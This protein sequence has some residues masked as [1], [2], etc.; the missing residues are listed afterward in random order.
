MAFKNGYLVNLII[1]NKLNNIEQ[2]NFFE[3]KIEN[4]KKYIIKLT[5]L[6]DKIVDAYL[7]I[8]GRKMGAYRIIPNETIDIVRPFRRTKDL[9]FLHKKKEYSDANLFKTN[10]KK[11]GEIEVEFCSG[12]PYP[13]EE[14]IEEYQYIRNKVVYRLSDYEYNPKYMNIYKRQKCKEIIKE[15]LTG[16]MIPEPEYEEVYL[17][18]DISEH[19]NDTEEN[20][21]TLIKNSSNMSCNEPPPPYT[22]QVNL[23]PNQEDLGFTTYGEKSDLKYKIYQALDYDGNSTKIKIY[24]LSKISFETLR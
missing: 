22:P 19:P 3:T 16:L 2:N 18:I 7:K 4:E 1:D 12:Q 8:D 6:N 15:Q 9:Y 14:D 11:L 5:N 17:P 13:K 24:L 23:P 21:D 10:N 20:L